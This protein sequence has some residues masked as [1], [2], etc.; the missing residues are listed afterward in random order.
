MPE[1]DLYS[2][3]VGQAYVR[4]M[5]HKRSMKLV[6]NAVHKL[7][8]GASFRGAPAAVE[9]AS[10]IKMHLESLRH[11]GKYSAMACPK[12]GFGPIKWTNCDDLL[13]HHNVN[14]VDNSCPSC[15]HMTLSAQGL[16]EWT[17]F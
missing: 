8:R 11:D 2:Q 12:C 1:K 13:A 14:G 7:A 16:V 6:E 3:E 5:L 15:G 10:H 9:F 4:E 17:P